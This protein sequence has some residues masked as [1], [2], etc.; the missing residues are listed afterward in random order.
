MLSL[1]A[2]VASTSVIDNQDLVANF[3]IS[4]IDS[5]IDVAIP[6]A[7]IKTEGSKVTSFAISETF[8]LTFIVIPI[9]PTWKGYSNSVIPLRTNGGRAPPELDKTCS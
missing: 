3:S 4:D 6:F 2:S 1:T 5:N 7:N 9:S 8:E